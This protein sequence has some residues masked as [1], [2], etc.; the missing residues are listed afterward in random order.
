VPVA[1]PS[2]EY[3]VNCSIDLSPLYG[4][5][6]ERKS[7]AITQPPADILERRLAELDSKEANE[8]IAA[9]RDLAY[10]EGQGERAFPALLT[11][12]EDPVESVATS[13][14]YSMNSYSDQIAKHHDVF[15]QMLRNQKTLPRFRD[16]A[17]YY[18]G[19]FAPADSAEVLEALEEAKKLLDDLTKGRMI[20]YGLTQFRKRMDAAGG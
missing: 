3:S 12:L 17:A 15:L 5:I 4:K 9:A 6:E 19:R 10:F 7:V 14:L 16:R 13:A 1:E 20:E 18:L 2:G 11:C 8:R